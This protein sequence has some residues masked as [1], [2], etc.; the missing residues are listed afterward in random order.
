MAR[1]LTSS[2]SCIDDKPATIT[3]TAVSGD[4]PVAN[5]YVVARRWPP[6]GL[7]TGWAGGRTDA[8]GR[9]Q[10]AGLAPGEYRVIALRALTPDMSGTSPAFERALAAGAKADLGPMGTVSLKIELS[11]PR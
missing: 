6:N 2:A 1:P 4:R 8:D 7:T 9:F 10:I 5:A 11:E 3:G